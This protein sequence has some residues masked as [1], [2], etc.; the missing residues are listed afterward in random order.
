MGI[1]GT[2][3]STPEVDSRQPLHNCPHISF[4]VIVGW[5]ASP[6]VLAIAGGMAVGLF[7]ADPGEAE[8]ILLFRKYARTSD[9]PALWRMSFFYVHNSVS[10]SASTTSRTEVE[11][12]RS[13]GQPDR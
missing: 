7:I 12:Q 10:P 5:I 13:R 11:S 3:R 2:S 4:T 6:V 9:Q 8:V 1:G